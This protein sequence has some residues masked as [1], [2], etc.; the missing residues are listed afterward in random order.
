MYITTVETCNMSTSD[1]TLKDSF[2]A[3]LDSANHIFILDVH[4]VNVI[5]NTIVH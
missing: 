1:I 4:V 5:G 2:K 3:L